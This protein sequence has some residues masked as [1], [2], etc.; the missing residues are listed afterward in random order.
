MKV[1]TVLLILSALLVLAGCADR[2]APS[3]AEVESARHGVLATATRGNPA[4]PANLAELVA[5]G[6][7]VKAQQE[8]SK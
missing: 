6:R 5:T 7:K 4:A 2:N 8:S 1:S 3:A